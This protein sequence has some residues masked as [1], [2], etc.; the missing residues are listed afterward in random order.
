MMVGMSEAISLTTSDGVRIA[1]D[2]YQAA[3]DR[4]VLLLHMMPA[5]RKSWA[6]LAGKLQEAGVQ[7]LAIDLRGHGESQ[8]GPN[9]YKSFSDAEHQSSR[10]DVEAGAAFLRGRGVKRLS[11]A[12]AS[13]GAN[14]A[15]QHLAEHPD[16]TAAA[17]LSPGL[18]Y[19]GIGTESLLR[20]VAP[21][22]RILLAASADD[23]YSYA[24]VERLRTFLAEG[25]RQVTEAARGGA[26]AVHI[27]RDAGHGTAIFDAE[28]AFADVVARWLAES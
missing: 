22:Q 24:S 5:T 17:L 26:S 25:G 6:V 19:R 27:F 13:I 12:G 4:G 9:G 2:L 1:G 11:L 14:L 10:L 21:H 3:G 20:R 8:G 18:D 7:S 16:A 15:L 28:P 23:D